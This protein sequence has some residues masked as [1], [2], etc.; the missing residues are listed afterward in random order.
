MEF[1]SIG[2]AMLA[3]SVSMQ[4]HIWSQALSNISE[5]ARKSQTLFLK[6]KTATIKGKYQ[7]AVWIP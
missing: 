6:V 7:L 1:A 3:I 4:Y 2:G 5:D